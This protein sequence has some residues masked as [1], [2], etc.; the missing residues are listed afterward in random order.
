MQE[1]SSPW[2]PLA[3]ARWTGNEQEEKG[4]RPRR[5]SDERNEGG[6]RGS[7]SRE[8]AKG[9]R[10]RSSRTRDRDLGF[11]RLGN[12][13]RCTG[14]LGIL[15]CDLASLVCERR[16]VPSEKSF[17]VIKCASVPNEPL[18]MTCGP[19]LEKSRCGVL[20]ERSHS[21]AVL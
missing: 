2:S 21:T 4:T 18:L 5:R 7:G 6:A 10:D 8:E 3:V 13:R 16:A 12:R 9:G 20:F 15:G 17:N 14:V 19:I 1:P 11:Y